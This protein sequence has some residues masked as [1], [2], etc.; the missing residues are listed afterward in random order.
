MGVPGIQSLAMNVTALCLRPAASVSPAFWS[1]ARFWTRRAGA[2]PYTSLRTESGCPAAQSVGPV[3]RFTSD[4][5][6]L[7][8]AHAT[9]PL[10]AA[11]PPHG[12]IFRNSYSTSRRTFSPE[13]TKP[14]ARGLQGESGYCHITCTD[15][16]R[17]TLESWSPGPGDTSRTGRPFPFRRRRPNRPSPEPE[18]ATRRQRALEWC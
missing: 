13:P 16:C 2:I 9:V 12:R 14:P 17:G 1:P 3:R 18:P 15:C 7:P 8:A 10:A 6:P 4:P 11:T 5:S